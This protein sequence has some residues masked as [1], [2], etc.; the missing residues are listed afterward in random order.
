MLVFSPHLQTQVRSFFL[1]I[2]VTVVVKY[3]HHAWGN[4]GRWRHTKRRTVSTVK[5]NRIGCV[6]YPIGKGRRTKIPRP[7]FDMGIY[8]IGA[9]TFRHKRK[10]KEPSPAEKGDRL[11]W[12]RRIFFILFKVENLRFSPLG[13]NFC[14]LFPF[15]SLDVRKYA[16]RSRTKN[17]ALNQSTLLSSNIRIQ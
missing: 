9:V 16:S 13:L 17:S 6:T 3:K 10:Q 8:F 5:P 1:T 15:F 12:M 2:R 4:G 7:F 14:L 11:R